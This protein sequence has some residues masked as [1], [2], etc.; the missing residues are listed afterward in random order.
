MQEERWSST[1]AK[2]NTAINVFKVFVPGAPV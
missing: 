2:F 1:F